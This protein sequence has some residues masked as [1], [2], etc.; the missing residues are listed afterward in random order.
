MY[1][2]GKQWLIAPIVFFGIL[3]LGI[4]VDEQVEASEV[5]EEVTELVLPES[6]SPDA[7]NL[8]NSDIVDTE[9]VISSEESSISEIQEDQVQEYQNPESDTI[10]MPMDQ[11]SE[12]AEEVT[13]NETAVEVSSQETEGDNQ[14]VSTPLQDENEDVEQSVNQTIQTSGI[15]DL[16]EAAKKIAQT[17]NESTTK[18]QVLAEKVSKIPIYRVYNPNSGEHL[19]TMNGNERDML[20]GIGWRNEGISMYVTDSGKELYRLYNPNSGEH[21]YTSDIGER[22]FLVTARW[23]DEGIAWYVLESGAA[24]YRV[25][26]PNATGAGS[27]HYTVIGSE[28]DDLVGRGWRDE[29]IAFYT[30]GG[31]NP[32][33]YNSLG[34]NQETIINELNKHANDNYYLGTPYHGITMNNASLY[35]KPGE[36]MNCTGFVAKVIQSAGGVLNKITDI[37]NRFGGVAN[38]YNWADALSR[39]VTSYT[40]NSVSDLLNSGKAKKGDI[41]YFVPDYSVANYDCHIGFFWG[42]ASNENTFWHSAPPANKISNLYAPSG[43]S[44]VIIFSM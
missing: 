16:K 14:E 9:A 15:I 8:E 26:N 17:S 35:M 3:A 1:K 25:F 21:F 19:H 41:I 6:S 18:Q 5:T 43:Y 22:D 28:R 40:F 33:T 12:A 37:A 30:L 24:M 4:S 27:H 7:V 2:A 31:A 29:G 36:S 11:S 42:N 34:V 39:L 20:V 13:K 32:I 10:E 38:A 23:N 44:K